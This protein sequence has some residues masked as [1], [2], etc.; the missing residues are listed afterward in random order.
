LLDIAIELN[1]SKASHHSEISHLEVAVLRAHGKCKKFYH[2]DRKWTLGRGSEEFDY[3]IL[4]LEEFT[5]DLTVLKVIFFL[6]LHS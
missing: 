5:V 2:Y 1:S 4:T 6:D 3:Q